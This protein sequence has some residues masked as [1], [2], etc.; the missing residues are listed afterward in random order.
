MSSYIEPPL[1]DALMKSVKNNIL[2]YYVALFAW[3]GFML[4]GTVYNDTMLVL[5]AMFFFMGSCTFYNNQKV[6]K[7][8]L[9]ILRRNY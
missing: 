8:R 5:D 2:F 3:V 7:A 1:E 9:E 6:D 4:Y